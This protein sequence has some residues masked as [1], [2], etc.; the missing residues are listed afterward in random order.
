[1]SKITG[2]RRLTDR[3]VVV[4]AALERRGVPTTVPELHEDFPHMRPSEIVRVLDSL[5][6]RGVVDWTG[7]RTWIYLGDVALERESEWLAA[8]HKPV[9]PEDIVR[10]WARPRDVRRE[11]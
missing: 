5:V 6:L 9:S 1:M 4:M 2:R 11:L 8:G 7:D 10:F 3:Q